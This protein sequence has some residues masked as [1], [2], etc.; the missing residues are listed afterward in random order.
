MIEN[1]F[2][3]M[4]PTLSGTWYNAKTGDSFTVRDTYFEGDEFYVL[5]TDGRRFNSSMMSQYVQSDV[6]IK[7]EPAPVRTTNNVVNDSIDPSIAALL[8]ED[9]VLNPVSKPVSVV[10]TPAPVVNDTKVY[11][12]DDMFIK[13]ALSK[14]P[15]PSVS[16]SI[17]WD[18]FPS[19]AMEMLTEYMY[20]DV[21]KICDYYISNID[22][23]DIKNSVATSIKAYIKKML[24][25]VESEQVTPEKHI[26]NQK[27]SSKK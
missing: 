4:G 11:D 14:A 1:V 17:K 25:P 9:P 21:D 24:Q 26:K 13:R 27:K 7:K 5:S 12:E 16:C 23:D 15:K 10:S 22:L 2:D 3:G 20:I 6:P 19:K 8:A 18:K